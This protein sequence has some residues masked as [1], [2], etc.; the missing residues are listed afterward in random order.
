M[1][2][3]DNWLWKLQFVHLCS[4]LWVPTKID[5]PNSC[6][7]KMVML[8]IDISRYV[9]GHV[10]VQTNPY[11]SYHTDKTVKDARSR[12]HFVFHL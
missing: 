12:S 2:Q 11:H 4:E 1:F 5:I 6:S 8:Q 3:P 7:C 9:T 10:H